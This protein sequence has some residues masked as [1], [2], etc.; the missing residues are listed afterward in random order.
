M[1]KIHASIIVLLFSFTITSQNALDFDG[2]DD[3]IGP[4]GSINSTNSITVE[5]W[6]NTTNIASQTFPPVLSISQMCSLELSGNNIAFW[7]LTNNGNYSSTQYTINDG[8][9][10]HV[11]GT[12]DGNIIQLYINGVQQT[13]VTTGG[14]NFLTNIGSWL[15]GHSFDNRFYKGQIDG[16]RVYN[17]VLTP[18]EIG[19]DWNLENPIST[20][21]L[22]ASYNF[23]QGIANGANST[24]TVLIDSSPAN[25]DAT[26]NNFSLTGTNS[27]WVSSG[28]NFSTLSVL[29]FTVKNT[30]RLYPNPAKDTFK[31]S[32]LFKI[33]NYSIYNTLGSLVKKGNISA[34]DEINIQN[35]TKGMYFLKLEDGNTFKFVKE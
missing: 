12:Y 6:I 7:V 1:K 29:D 35:L 13:S 15:I 14:A 22:I 30:I 32:G 16:V 20:A 5:A 26:L 8:Q 21:D 25:N 27:N 4:A 11:A 23:N 10:Y 19:A 9:W 33:K 2:I 18:M 24:I 17:R 3:Y 28:V 34:I 31:L